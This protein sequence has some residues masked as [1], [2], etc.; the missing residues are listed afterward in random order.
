MKMTGRCR[1]ALFCKIE[2][3]L[4]MVILKSAQF[5]VMLV[6]LVLFVVQAFVPNFPL[7]DATL[8]KIVYFV[9]AIFGIYPE[10]K[11]RGLL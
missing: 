6:A 4:M 10:L 7:D 3:R 5:W 11:A 8:L 9:L 2:K 1:S